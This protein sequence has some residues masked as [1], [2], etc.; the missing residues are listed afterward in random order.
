MLKEG[1]IRNNVIKMAEELIKLS[2]NPNGS[3]ILGNNLEGKGKIWLYRVQLDRSNVGCSWLT[4]RA[5][6]KL[7][8]LGNPDLVE[9]EGQVRS[10]VNSCWRA[11]GFLWIRCTHPIS[12]GLCQRAPSIITEFSSLKP[13]DFAVF[14]FKCLETELLSKETQN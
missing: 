2:V 7:R 4:K 1:R 3:C 10:H 9:P 5:Y 12:N 6:W 14:Y 8:Q 11:R 13:V